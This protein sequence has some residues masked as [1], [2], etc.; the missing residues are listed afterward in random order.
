MNL[1]AAR[2]ADSRKYHF[3]LFD[4]E[5]LLQVCEIYEHT[6]VRYV[7]F[8]KHLN[9]PEKQKSPKPLKSRKNMNR[10]FGVLLLVIVMAVILITAFYIYDAFESIRRFLIIVLPLILLAAFLITAMYLYKAIETMGRIW[11]IVLPLILLMVFSL[12]IFLAYIIFAN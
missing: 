5:E 8:M 12:L 7:Q 9:F 3:D 6:N 10:I 11:K 1:A 2:S 4:F